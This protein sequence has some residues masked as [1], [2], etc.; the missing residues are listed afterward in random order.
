[1]KFSTFFQTFTCVKSIVTISLT[2]CFIYLCV[3]GSI[4]ADNFMAVYLMIIGFY[5]GTQWQKKATEEEKKK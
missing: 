2:A 4:S 3:T 5:F 1:M